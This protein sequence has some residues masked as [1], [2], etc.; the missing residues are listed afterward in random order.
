MNTGRSFRT[1]PLAALGLALCAATP[2]LAQQSSE[3]ELDILIE[4]SLTPA[5]ALELANRQ[6][7]EG[8]LLGA[9]ATLERALL[10]NPEG[11]TARVRLHY[12][13]LLCRLDDR[14]T[15]QSELAKVDGLD[16]G[17][18]D[19][20]RV[21]AACGEVQRPPAGPL[22]ERQGLTGEVAFGLSYDSDL[23][24]A[25]LVQF[26]L[27]GSI[28]ADD[29]LSFFGSAFVAGRVPVGTR[30]FAYGSAGA[31]TKNNLGGPS[32]NFQTG[33]AQL[34]L[35][36]EG[37]GLELSAGVTGGHSIISSDPFLT[38]YGGEAELA[39]VLAGDAR[40]SLH[41]E[42]VHQDYMGST[43]AFSRDGTRID[44]SLDYQGRSGL[45]TS[46]WFGI[47]YE[48]KSAETARTGYQGLRGFGSLRETVSGSGVYLSAFGT[49]RYA[50]YKDEI[51]F[52]PVNELRW[53]TRGAVGV[54]VL[55]TG[56]NLEAAVSYTWRVYN[57]ASNFRNYESAGAELRLVWNFGN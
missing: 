50:E 8:D 18:A 36:F 11:N 7:S 40:L 25:L 17:D 21:Q 16:I 3:A 44:V 52:V 43:P 56:L 46:Y 37:N 33:D 26:N 35:G 5:D 39:I 51:G 53:Y 4:R 27:P 30:T 41:G 34:G 38:E 24:N 49:I 12:V 31:A 23:A 42:L 45:A 14:Q 22:R 57:D 6:E 47:A 29:G 9:A 2:A 55:T 20:S 10:T 28:P 1:L 32:L 15:A 48:N 13:G 54:P 19:W